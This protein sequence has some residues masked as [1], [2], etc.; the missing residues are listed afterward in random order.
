MFM[1]IQDLIFVLI[2]MNLPMK[3]NGKNN[4]NFIK[5]GFLVAKQYMGDGGV[6]ECRIFNFNK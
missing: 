1:R 3:L 2:V 5:N 6:Y 4:M